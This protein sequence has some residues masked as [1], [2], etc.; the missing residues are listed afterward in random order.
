MFVV[1]DVVLVVVDDIFVVVLLLLLLVLFVFL[2]VRLAAMRHLLK[3]PPG[4]LV[5]CENW[6]SLKV[7]VSI[8][9]MDHNTELAVSAL[10]V[11]LVGASYPL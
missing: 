1:D 9:L 10:C 7:A 2:Q 3:F 5:S 6:S 4:D 8:A 11:K